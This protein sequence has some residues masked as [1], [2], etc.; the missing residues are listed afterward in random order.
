MGIIVKGIT[1][2]ALLIKLDKTKTIDANIAEMN[3]KLAAAF[4]KNS[5]VAVDTNE[6]PLAEADKSNIEE[7]LR[8]SGTNFLGYKTSESVRADTAREKDTR[9]KSL[10]D[11]TE[12]KAAHIVNKTMRSG[13]RIEHDGDVL[14]IG[15]VNPDAYIIASGN[16]VVMGILRGVVHA[17]ARGD[18]TAVIMALKLKPQ[19]LRIAGCFTRPPDDMQT[20]EYPEKAFVRD[21]QIYIE[22]IQA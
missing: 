18:E 12:K 8:K 10:P 6:I 5:A 1:V 3:E 9:G 7:A 21:N 4:F 19:Q 15:D 13:Q 14:V 22:K 20:P 2:P 17:G 16:I 11:V